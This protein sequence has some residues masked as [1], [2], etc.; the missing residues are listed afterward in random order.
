MWD[1]RHA[2][3]ATRL[4]RRILKPPFAHQMDGVYVAVHKTRPGGIV[5]VLLLTLFAPLWIQGQSQPITTRGTTLHTAPQAQQEAPSPPAAISPVDRAIPLPQIADRAEEMDRWLRESTGQLTPDAELL[6]SE[7][8]M[9]SES[10]E[11]QK[12]ALEVDELLAGTPTTLELKEEQRF[13]RTINQR[14]AEQRKQLTARAAELEKQV[15]FLEEQQLNWQATWDQIRDKKDIDAVLEQTRQE[16]EAIRNGRAQIGKQ[17]NSALTLQN[18]VVQIDRQ[19]ADVLSMVSDAQDRLRSRLFQR[20]GRPLWKARELGSIPQSAETGIRQTF[21]QSFRT[22]N[23]F[24]QLNKVGILS[25]VGS[26]FLALFAALKLQQ[27]LKSGTVSG[28]PEAAAKVF[29]S[30][31]SIALLVAMVETV[32]YVGSAPFNVALIIY[33]LNLIPV[34]RLLSPLLDPPLRKFLRVLAAFYALE[35]LYLLIRFPPGLRQEMHAMIVLGALICFAWLAR[36]SAMRAMSTPRRNLRIVKVGTW[37]GLTLLALSLAA[38]VFGYVSL[39][40]ILGLSALLGA[41]TAVAIYCAAR[42]LMVVASTFLRSDSIRS[43]IETTPEQIERWVWRGLTFGCF[44]VWCNAMLQLLMIHDYVVGSVTA[45]LSY[46]IGFERVHITLKEVLSF[47]LVLLVG[48]AVANIFTLLL[49]KVFLA[50]FSLQRGLPFAISKVTYYILLVLAFVVALTNAGIQLDKFTLVTGAL[51]VGVGFGLQSIVNNFLSGLILLFERPIRVGDVVETKGLVG[52]VR[53]IGAR[54]STIHTF[55]DA[56]VIVPNSNLV[57]NEVI[58]WTL[59]SV[60]RRVDIPLNVAYGTDPEKVLSLLLNLVVSYPGIAF[61]P[62]PEAYFLGFGENGLRF[63]LRFWTFQ[64]DWFRLKSDVTVTLVKALRD[65]NIE[66]P[67][68][69]RDLRIR[70]FNTARIESLSTADDLIA[71]TTPVA[72]KEKSL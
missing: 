53:R 37:L 41:F 52:R 10:D 7:Q 19:I 36:P 43:V 23:V 72:K 38:N 58:N 18:Q 42:V 69:Q 30:P 55:E 6:D 14:Y 47:V 28:A 51:G 21:D 35:V 2:V 33:M 70:D 71:A 68:P 17:L 26:F 1:T 46:P 13:W 16:L 11:L 45:A 54:S 63:E 56:E 31:F 64:E 29:A 32:V 65:A 48:Y 61:N 39:A 50:K 24:L 62:A 66:I 12:R 4:A 27:Y 60:R 59:S 15:R 40:Q 25:I 34:L 9:K 22:S 3:C 44:I 5:A 57:S 49:R 8:E 67:L 20:D